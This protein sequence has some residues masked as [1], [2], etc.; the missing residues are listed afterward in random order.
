MKKI[1]NDP[2]KFADETIEGILKAY[3]RHLKSV[4]DNNR[5]LVRKE[6]PV[7]NKVAIVTGGGSGHLPVFL[8]YVGKGLCDGVAVGN[9]FSSPSAE[10]IFVATLACNGGKGVLYLYGNYQGDKM[11]FNM[12]SEL[13][14]AEGIHIEHAIVHD[15]IASAPVNEMS[16][17]RA[18]A[19]LFF[20]YKIAGAKAEQNAS[21]NEV[22]AITEK[23]IENT[24][25]IGVALSSCIL[26]LVGKPTFYIGE[27]E[28]EIGMGIHG[29]PGIERTKIKK[30]SEIA[31]AMIEKLIID[32]PLRNDEEIAV[33]VNG[34]G[35]TPM[36]ELF[37]LWNNAY[38]ILKSR[39][40]KIYKCFIGEYA[41]SMEMAGC[42]I[43]ILRLDSEIK[44][45]LDYPAYSP[46]LPQWR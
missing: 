30:A 35:A 46:F 43:S 42:S 36:E 25:S 1:I 37:I 18:I 28:M 2:L 5:V 22:K 17:R 12:A 29:E 8:G 44:G 39:D 20:A 33:L 27:N 19:G 11:N 34:L 41:T 4:P 23:T 9:V 6:C 21:L 3:P 16:A 15:D 13:S 31:D 38:D 10:N 26:P 14:V 7:K 45:L 24:R 40:I 32:F